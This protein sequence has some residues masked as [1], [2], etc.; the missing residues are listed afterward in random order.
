MIDASNEIIIDSK[1]IE[2]IIDKDVSLIDNNIDVKTLEPEYEITIN[3]KEYNVVGDELYIPK[4][5]EDAP[6]WLRDI[7]DN[8]TDVALSAKISEINNL[9]QSLNNLI[10]ELEVAKNT[11]TMSV[12]SSNDINERINTAITTL[13]SSVMESDATIL[14]LATTRVTPEQAQAISIDAIRTSLNDTISGNSLGSIISGM[15]S[16]TTTGDYTNAQSIE[17]LQSTIEGNADSTA[18]A[19]NT[20][21]TFAGIDSAGAYTYTGL[22]GYL[23]DPN[24]GMIGG[25][26]SELQNTITTTGDKVEAK[27]EYGSNIKIGGQYHNAGFGLKTTMTGGDGTIAD[28]YN[29]EFWINAEKFKFT[30]NSMSGQATPFSI[31]ATGLQPKIT[32]NGLVTFG[33][34]QTGTIEEAISSTIETVQVGDKNINI[35]DNLIPTTSFVSDTNNA[36]YQF[37][38]DVVKAMQTG[39]STFAEAQVT[40]TSGSEVYSPYVDEIT[41]P[42]YYRFAITGVTNI[43]S[44]KIITIDSANQETEHIISV[45]LNAG[46]TLLATN[47]YIIEGIINPIGGNSATSG[48]IRDAL[49]NKLGTINNYPMPSSVLK[50]V[51]GWTL[52]C[53]ISRMK[54]CK[55]TADTITESYATTDYVSEVVS[56]SGYVRPSEVADAINNNITTINGSKI[57]T[58]TILADKINTTGL[59]AENISAEEIA[60]KTISGGRIIGAIIEGVVIKASYLDLDG[61]LEVLTNYHLCMTQAKLNAVIAAGG[62]GALYTNGT[63]MPDAV[64]IAISDEY[65]IPSISQI[66]EVTATGSGTISGKIYSYDTSNAHSNYKAVRLKPYVRVESMF[67]LISINQSDNIARAGLHYKRSFTP[68]I[69]NVKFGNLTML[70]V[71]CDRYGRSVSPT[72]LPLTRFTVERY[73]T[74]TVNYD[75]RDDLVGPNIINVPVTLGFANAVLHISCYVSESSFN[76]VTISAVLEV[77]PTADFNPTSINFTQGELIMVTLEHAAGWQYEPGALWDIPYPSISTRIDSGITINNML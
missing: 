36:G 60:G 22:T 53:T 49:N 56:S 32:F 69:F 4:R 74:G 20:I 15:Q 16:T 63:L 19:I 64:Y 17:V 40:L 41:V 43:D 11:Y 75:F 29:S 39:V 54:L 14:G 3:R 33:S 23:V 21:N 47:W 52:S 57:T 70:R 5:Y 9:T 72:A 35:S 1:D 48:S 31:D 55:I 45:N 71:L 13:N 73:N 68:F 76:Q 61:E 65:R 67:N 58:G 38:G 50:L 34:G 6:Q 42:Y 10:D 30:N 46:I 59:I 25:G 66:R 24:T 18:T 26:Q 2:V 7:I 51:L 62:T 37:V 27:F 28:P 8:V 77:I 44:F 12:I